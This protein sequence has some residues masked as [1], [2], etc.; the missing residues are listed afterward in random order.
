MILGEIIGHIRATILDDDVF[1]MWCFRA[2]QTKV[3]G[4]RAIGNDTNPGNVTNRLRPEGPD[5]EPLR[6]T[7]LFADVSGMRFRFKKS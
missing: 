5:M 2:E 7:A 4:R 3:T 1:H 6:L